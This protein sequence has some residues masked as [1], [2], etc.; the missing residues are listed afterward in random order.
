MLI[1]RLFRKFKLLLGPLWWYS[2][3]MFGVMR[4]GDI[5]NAYIGAFL[6]PQK[7]PEDLG[8]VRALVG[9]VVLAGIPLSFLVIPVEKYLNVFTERDERGK[10]KALL[11]DACLGICLFTALLALGLY[12]FAHPL[13]ERLA[14]SDV[15]WL[16]WT[17]PVVGLGGL[18]LVTGAALRAFKLFDAA[19]VT[20]LPGTLVR[21]V[22]MSL[23]LG[24]FSLGG[25]LMANTGAG[26]MSVLV[27]GGLLVFHFRKRPAKTES[28]RRSW[29]EMLWY[30]LPL[31]VY[32][33]AVNIQV[34][35]EDI[36]IRQRLPRDISNAAYIL[37][38]F[39]ELP[40]YF[41]LAIALF[42]FPMT[43]S[44]FERGE[45]TRPL[46]VQSL[47]VS[48]LLGL[49]CVAMLHVAL[50]YVL[51][52]N[53]A[54]MPAEDYAWLAWIAGLGC[55]FRS[56]TGCL[57]VHQHACRRFSYLWVYAPAILLQTLGLFLLM[58]WEFFDPY[59][60]AGLW[61][62]VAT[63]PRTTLPFVFVWSAAWQ[64]IAFLGALALSRK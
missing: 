28:Y 18:G 46:L 31:L 3:L 37:K 59:L 39:A 63:L 7:I 57:V 49:G 52:L 35:I 36:L 24:A 41:G 14:I 55:T 19:V 10:A 6:V 45:D 32:S 9:I 38:I 42:L 25:Y 2:L 56:C 40:M 27:C 5:A 20:A 15:R 22:L 51:G 23:L 34:P 26:L 30:A 11:R 62:W 53:P 13:M 33:I 44:R 58:G 16:L 29:R 48:A 21:L 64:G 4:F 60:P 1:P 47:V 54:W 61:G 12:A 8:T 50:P 17:A 43:S